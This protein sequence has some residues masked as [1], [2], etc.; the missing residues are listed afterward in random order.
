MKK[1]LIGLL[2]VA[3]LVA[4]TFAQPA[5][6][7]R[8]TAAQEAV[9]VTV[10]VAQPSVS[11]Q[12]S[13][14]WLGTLTF[15]GTSDGS[16][17]VT[18]TVSNVTAATAVTT[19]TGNGVFAI[20]NPGY[21]T[22]RV[23]ASAWTTGTANVVFTV[24]GSSGGGGSGGSGG[25]GCVGTAGAPCIVAG[26]DAAG[27]PTAGT[28]LAVQGITSMTPVQVSQATAASLNAQV[29][30]NVAS[31]AS[32]SGNPV[33][34]GGRYNSTPIVLT[35]G[36]RGDVQLNPSGYQL[37][38]P[39]QSGAFAQDATVGSTLLTT[40][41]LILC[42]GNSTAPTAVTTGQPQYIH[43]NL[44]GQLIM[45]PRGPL[46]SGVVTSAMTG[47]TSTS[48]VSGTGSNYLYIQSCI[49]SNSSLTVSTDINLQDGSGGTVLYVLPAPA[50]AVA[51]TGGGG[52]T[53][54][55]GDYGLK[56][57]TSGNALFAVNVTTG[58]STKI[59]CNGYR[60]TVS[61]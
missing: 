61:Y 36:Q 29:V 52:A 3:T 18:L 45:G 56:V 12:V 32:D 54:Y 27:T 14:T 5:A 39:S 11:M 17:F 2:L 57:P 15:E 43:C 37:V 20:A 34:V 31:G 50:A 9:S 41:P 19:T 47:T 8:I 59:S 44:N 21:S 60:S 24:G 26:N 35:N 1:I 22:V 40:G 10:S 33:K 7:G 30:G 46:V 51:T 25:S 6:F 55:F 38:A 48:V 4:P 49:V 23:R 53:H 42:D 16:N 13:G 28:V 58:S